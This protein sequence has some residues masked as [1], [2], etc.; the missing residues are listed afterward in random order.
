MGALRRR[1]RG[2]ARQQLDR[3]ETEAD[4]GSGAHGAHGARRPCRRGPLEP[5]EP[6]RGVQHE[7]YC[8]VGSRAGFSREEHE[9]DSDRQHG[10]PAQPGR[11]RGGARR[12]EAEEGEQG[13]R[14]PA[15]ADDEAGVGDLGDHAAA[16][17]ER[18]R[19]RPAREDP[20]PGRPQEGIAAERCGRCGSDQVHGPGRDPRQQREEPREG[21]GRARVP[22]CEQRRASPDVRVEDGEA[23]RAEV[24]ADQLPEREVLGEVVAGDD[25]VAEGGWEGVHEERQRHEARDRCELRAAPAEGA[26]RAAPGPGALGLRALRPAEGGG[27]AGPG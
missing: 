9:T 19:P 8:D 27:S 20:E 15:H 5:Y 11:P 6:P 12:R 26:G 14:R 1:D 25:R 21:V 7:H 10:S 3:A 22:P 2:E 13:E 23:A 4:E 16:E 24:P 17:G 18:H